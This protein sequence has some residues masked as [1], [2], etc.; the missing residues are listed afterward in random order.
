MSWIVLN[1]GVVWSTGAGKHW[2]SDRRAT[3][4]PSALRF[5]SYIVLDPEWENRTSWGIQP[6]PNITTLNLWRRRNK[7]VSCISF[8]H[9]GHSQVLIKSK[10]LFHL[11]YLLIFPACLLWYLGW[12]Q[13]CGNGVARHDHYTICSW[14]TF[15]TTGA[16]W[17]TS[18]SSSTKPVAF[19]SH[20]SHA[21]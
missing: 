8:L 5:S 13:R 15:A 2:A 16:S 17:I 4:R 19:V 11:V 6:S 12:G 20:S 7:Q 18:S 3:T 9:E 1:L 21:N 10:Y 14:P